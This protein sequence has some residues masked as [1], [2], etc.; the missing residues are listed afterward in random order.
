MGHSRIDQVRA[1]HQRAVEAI[2]SASAAA[3]T[4]ADLMSAYL[5]SSLEAARALSLAADALAVTI[6][7]I[8][9]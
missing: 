2:A 1:A 9:R 8:D 7:F 5:S 6:A 4:E 3:E